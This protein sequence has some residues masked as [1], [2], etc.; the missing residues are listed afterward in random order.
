VS[1]LSRVENKQEGMSDMFRPF[2]FWS[3]RDVVISLIA[4]THF[5]IFCSKRMCSSYNSLKNYYN[6]ARIF[7]SLHKN[8][9]DYVIP[10]G[11]L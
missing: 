10:L 8:T 5:N 1:L 11:D 3:G 4:N 6:V 2:E 7:L 9:S